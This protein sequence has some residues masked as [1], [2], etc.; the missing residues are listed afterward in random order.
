[1]TPEQK[2]GFHE[3][4]CASRCLIALANQSRNPITVEQFLERYL[5]DRPYW[6]SKNQWGGTETSDV[7]DIARD[8][9]LATYLQIY[10]DPAK[11]KERMK[12]GIKFTLLFT[13]KRMNED[14]TWRNECH[15]SLVNMQNTMEGF[16]RVVQ[17]TDDIKV[18]GDGEVLSTQ[19]IAAAF[20]YFGVFY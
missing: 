9:G 7:L 12:S 11:A 6:Q 19:E 18:E 2:K 17:V 3:Y 15:V 16:F 5:K 13:E 1:M 4:G 8:L 10:I 20:G 14:G